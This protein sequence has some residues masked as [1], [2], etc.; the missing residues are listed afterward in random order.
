MKIH[1]IREITSIEELKAKIK[2]EEKNLEELKFLLA[3]RQLEN[4]AK[5]RNTKKDIAR[6]KT[7]LT[8]RE[9]NIRVNK[10]N[11]K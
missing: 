4:T 7:V 10:K 2:E 9:R 11:S 6:M 8:E 1:E 5:I 3:T